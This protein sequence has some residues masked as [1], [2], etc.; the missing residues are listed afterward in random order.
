MCNKYKDKLGFFV[1]K[2]NQTSPNKCK[3]LI[4][5]KNKLDIADTS[6]YILRDKHKGFKELIIGFKM[7]YVNLFSIFC[8]D[9]T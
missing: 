7:I 1:L 4:R 5:L 2:I 3:F 6:M 9:V 8:L